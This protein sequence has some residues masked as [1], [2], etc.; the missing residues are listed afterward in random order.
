MVAG[1]VVAGVV[2]LVDLNSNL[3]MISQQP[4]YIQIN[5]LIV[6]T[7]EFYFLI[8]ETFK[9]YVNNTDF[10]SFMWMSR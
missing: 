6:G 7:E 9:L 8:K 10:F 5:V 2:G 3:Q 1:G 4:P